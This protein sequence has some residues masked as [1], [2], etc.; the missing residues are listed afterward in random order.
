MSWEEIQHALRSIVDVYDKMAIGLTLGLDARLRSLATS[1]AHGCI[2]DLGC[3]TGRFSAYLPSSRIKQLVLL[4]PIEEMIRVARI[5]VPDSDV[6]I[7]VAEYLPFRAG[8][9]D[10]VLMGYMLRDVADLPKALARVI[11]V[12]K[13]EGKAVVLDFW[14]SKSPLL[15]ALEL[16]YLVVVVT[17]ISAILAPRRIKHYL[18]V[19]KTLLRNPPIEG[20]LKILSRRFNRVK[21]I[22]LALGFLNIIIA[23]V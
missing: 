6:I 9:M 8:S 11:N 19:Y 12:L 4:D 10:F 16:F 2:L 1:F 17:L 14:R 13:K 15:F 3:G 22:K 18:V 7:G 23:E 20:L 21:R 5:R